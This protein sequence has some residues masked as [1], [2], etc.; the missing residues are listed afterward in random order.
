MK[1]A[2]HDDLNQDIVFEALQLDRDGGRG[3]PVG[4]E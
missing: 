4:D 3:T 2:F 1:I